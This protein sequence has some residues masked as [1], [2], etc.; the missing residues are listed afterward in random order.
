MLTPPPKTAPLQ[1][2][3]ALIWDALHD[4]SVFILA[5]LTWEPYRKLGRSNG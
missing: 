2:L 1:D 4:G 3:N 5:W